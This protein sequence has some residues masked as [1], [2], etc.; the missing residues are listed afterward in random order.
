MRILLVDHRVKVR[1]ALR[2]LVEQETEVDFVGEISDTKL[3]L[4]VV[5]STRP[6]VVLIDWEMVKGQADE[7]LASLNRRHP[8]VRI[9]AM[10]G[11]PES[12][13]KVLELGVDAFISKGDPPELLIDVLR[14]CF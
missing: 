14:T 8:E 6:D 12:R 13:Q 11:R 1:S 10:S 3:L 5:E 2:L 9:I 7:L 4:E